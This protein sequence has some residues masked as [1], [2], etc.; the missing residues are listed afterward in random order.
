MTLMVP[1]VA[2]SAEAMGP[3]ANS[4]VSAT[5]QVSC[6]ILVLRVRLKIK[7]DDAFRPL[8]MV[9]LTGSGG[10]DQSW[11]HKTHL[12]TRRIAA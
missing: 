2:A 10:S 12:E 7:L 1:D 4:A 8:R 3:T 11:R 6:F 9:G 5:K